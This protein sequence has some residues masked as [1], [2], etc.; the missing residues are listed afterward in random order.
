MIEIIGRP[1][2]PAQFL[3]TSKIAWVGNLSEINSDPWH[4]SNISWIRRR[5]LRY[6][7]KTLGL[8]ILADGRSGCLRCLSEIGP[9]VSVLY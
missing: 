9:P 4:G 6:G 3:T 5:C 2:E 7:V 8:E 1:N